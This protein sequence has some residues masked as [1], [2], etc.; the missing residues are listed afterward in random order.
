MKL[1][2]QGK[3]AVDGPK[4]G[5]RSWLVLLKVKQSISENWTELQPWIYFSCLCFVNF[6]V[7]VEAWKRKTWTGH[8]KR[9]WKATTKSSTASKKNRKACEKIVFLSMI[10]G[11]NSLDYLYLADGSGMEFMGAR[12]I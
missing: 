5:V 4:N 3:F 2:K 10:C 12:D 8:E 6:E 7:H 11:W 9:S 1:R